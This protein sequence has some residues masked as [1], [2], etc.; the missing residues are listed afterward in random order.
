MYDVCGRHGG[1]REQALVQYTKEKF[2]FVDAYEQSKTHH[3]SHLEL[4]FAH[5]FSPNNRPDGFHTANLTD[6]W[7]WPHHRPPSCFFFHVR[8][9]MASRLGS[10]LYKVLLASVCPLDDRSPPRHLQYRSTPVL[11]STANSCIC[12]RVSRMH[13]GILC[14]MFKYMEKSV[15]LAMIICTPDNI[16]QPCKPRVTSNHL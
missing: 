7:E 14:S 1:K 8:Q 3:F 4:R 2:L 12:G 6:P 13:A 16:V 10:A 11:L 5:P 9:V 15:H